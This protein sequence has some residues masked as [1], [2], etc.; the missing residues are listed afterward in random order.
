MI[1]LDLILGDVFEEG[2]NLSQ[3]EQGCVSDI[4][5]KGDLIVMLCAPENTLSIVLIT[6]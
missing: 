6:Q 4:K 5:I 3:L 1:T 2:S